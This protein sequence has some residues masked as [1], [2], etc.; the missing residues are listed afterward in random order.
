MQDNDT[1]LHYAAFYGHNEIANVLLKAGARVDAIN[2]VSISII[3]HVVITSL[4]YILHV[5]M[6]LIYVIMQ[7]FVVQSPLVSLYVDTPKTITKTKVI[8]V[9]AYIN[10]AYLHNLPSCLISEVINKSLWQCIFKCYCCQ[11]CV[12]GWTN[13]KM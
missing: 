4:D 13:F 6:L 12:F 7:L 8:I 2:N 9:V 11:S 5:I 1:A 3:E 10:S